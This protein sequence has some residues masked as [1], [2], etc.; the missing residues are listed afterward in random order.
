[1][2]ESGEGLLKGFSDAELSA[3]Q[4][5]K[6]PP[7]LI[8]LYLSNTLIIAMD[9]ALQFY[10]LMEQIREGRPLSPTTRTQEVTRQLDQGL[11]ERRKEEEDYDRRM[12]EL[13]L[14]DEADHNI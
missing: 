5:P 14:S 13:V 10:I 12:G 9:Y 3:I 7:P 6:S 1:M 4:T 11:E 2:D 8:K